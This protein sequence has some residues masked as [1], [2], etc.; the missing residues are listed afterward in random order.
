MGSSKLARHDRLFLLDGDDDDDVVD[1]DE[2]MEMELEEERRR[3]GAERWVGK[4]KKKTEGKK[5]GS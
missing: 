4:G 5:K 3:R 1:Y 2:E